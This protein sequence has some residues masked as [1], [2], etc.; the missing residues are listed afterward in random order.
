MFLWRCTTGH[1]AQRDIQGHRSHPLA[2]RSTHESGLRIRAGIHGP[3]QQRL[4]RAH[5]GWSC[6][7]SRLLLATPSPAVLC[8][9]T[10]IWP[11]RG[12]LFP[13]PSHSLCDL[14]AQGHFPSPC[15]RRPAGWRDISG[16]APRYLHPLQELV[17]D[18]GA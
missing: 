3:R 18:L 12:K 11:L 6:E 16:A 14:H 17:L 4:G 13:T 5:S 10:G 15:E 8:S 2:P 1:R 7:S 9:S